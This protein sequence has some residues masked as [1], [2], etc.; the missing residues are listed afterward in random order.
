[1]QL[2]FLDAGI[3]GFQ[4]SRRLRNGRRW[5]WLADEDLDCFPDRCS[6]VLHWLMK[7]ATAESRSGHMDSMLYGTV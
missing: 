6:S 4:R 3:Q 2:P 7:V 5:G 1:M